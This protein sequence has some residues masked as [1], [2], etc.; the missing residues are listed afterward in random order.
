MFG[1]WMTFRYVLKSVERDFPKCVGG[2]WSPAGWPSRKGHTRV[3]RVP[4]LALGSGTTGV[5]Y[6][7][8]PA[9]VEF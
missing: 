8:L 7:V 5:G 2:S 6:A 3:T 1:T 9:V 4:V